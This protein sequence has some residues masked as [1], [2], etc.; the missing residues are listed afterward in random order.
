[1]NKKRKN[2]FESWIKKEW[3]RPELVDRVKVRYNGFQLVYDIQGDEFSKKNVLRE[4]KN[5]NMIYSL[6][7]LLADNVNINLLYIKRKDDAEGMI[8]HEINELE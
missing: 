4:V 8:K 5:S 2:V 7:S 6:Q 1:M 3:V